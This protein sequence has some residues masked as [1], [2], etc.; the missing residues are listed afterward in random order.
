MKNSSEYK[1][2]LAISTW[3]K[4]EKIAMQKV[5]EEDSFTMGKRVK[6]Y[7]NMF[8]EYLNSKYSV[9]V[10][11]GSSA[12]LLMIASL[13]FTKNPKYKLKKGDEVIVPAVSWG[14]TYFPLQQYGLKVKF[15]DINLKTLNLDLDKLKKA[16]TDKTR[17]ILAVNLL[18][19]PNDF[20]EISNIV[21]SRNIIILEDN[22]ES[23]SAKFD[24]KLT[25]TFGLMGTF[26]SFF[27][28]HIS[29]MEGGLITTNEREIYEILLSLR[30]HGWTRELP[31]DNLLTEGKENKFDDNYNFILPGYNV[32]PLE[33]EAAAGIEQL[34]KLDKMITARRKNAEIFKEAL[35]K[36]NNLIIQEEIGESSWFGF[37]LVINPDCGKKRKEL[38]KALDQIGIEY[39]PIVAGNFVN[40]SAVK[41]F[42]Y[43]I[44]EELNN[45]D[46]IDNNGLFIGNSHFDLSDMV[47]DLSK[48]NF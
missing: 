28:H 24:N 31:K 47:G 42:D 6:E 26:S 21:K 34:K 13:F 3:G 10:N 8:S 33:I 17:V 11:S 38:T 22:C 20:R 16:V 1:H 7:E 2:C 36:Q 4:E 45:A 43:E 40:K 12:N 18:G 35:N 9:M 39:R 48:I 25:G 37:S 27:S 32:R 14:T 41:F 44:H 19:N 46:Y 23:L 30:A 29:T 5:I 15:V